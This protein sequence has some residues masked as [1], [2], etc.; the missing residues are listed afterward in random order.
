MQDTVIDVQAFINR[1]RFSGY[2][3]RILLLCFFIVAIDGFDTAALGFIAPVLAQQWHIGKA[4]LGPVLSAALVGLAVGALVA[5]PLA[6]RYGRKKVIVT[7]VVLFGLGSLA[8]AGAWSLGSMTL[9]RFLTGLGLGA[10]MP[11]ATTLLAEYSPDRRRSLLVT[12]MFCGFT[13]G[14]A[15]AGFVAAK[16]IP[17]YG[18]PSVLALG[19]A[20]P[21]LLSMLLIAVLPESVRFLVLKG[22]P[23]QRVAAMLERIAPLP[24]SGQPATGSL[25][26]SV[27]EQTLSQSGSS[28]RAIFAAPLGLGTVMLWLGYF[29]GLL[30]IYLVTSWLPTLIKDAGLPLEKAALVAAMFMFGGTA[31]AILM[32]WLMDRFRPHHVLTAFY[33][34][35][36]LFIFLIG[37]SAGDLGQLAVVVF[38]AGFCIN[39][40]QVSMS[41]LAAG[42]YPT[43]CRATGVSWMLGIG[44]FGGILGALI[45]GVL[46][47]AGWGFA[48]IFAVLALPAA[49]AAGAIAVKGA[50]YR[51]VNARQSPALETH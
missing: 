48:T 18:W 25:A 30:V 1:Q 33:L 49:L 45:G 12:T 23:P 7:S 29:M 3:W 13:L 37:R 20:L 36:A 39:G 28:L 38:G 4:A 19:G 9:F 43:L 2:Q 35:G 50:H 21:L 24:H 47:G 42:F 40:A 32:G 14:S 16:L 41:A 15:S 5:G 34:C 17:A 46:L 8:S 51:S 6:D 31:G 27:P 44:R 10:A 11:N 26:F 22:A